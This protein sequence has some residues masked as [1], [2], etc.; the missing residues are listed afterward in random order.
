[1]KIVGTGP[2]ASPVQAVNPWDAIA[3]IGQG[4]LALAKAAGSNSL[5]GFA[6]V[7]SNGSLALPAST[8]TVSELINE[9]L[10]A[11]ARLDRS[12]RYL[13][14]LRVSLRSFGEGRMSR[15][16]ASVTVQDVE[17]WL[18][19]NGWAP[20]TMKGYLGDVRTMFN[21][22]IK[23]GYL[24]RS[25]ALAVELP[26]IDKRNPPE[27]YSPEEV[28]KILE[29]LRV[30]DLNVCR[31]VA[32][33]FFAGV[34]NAETHRLR[35]TDLKLDL[36]FVEVPALK[37]KTRARRLVKIRPNL[38]AW[39]E[40]GGEL[41]A[42]SDWT[43]RKALKKCGVPWKANAPRH[44]FVSYHLAQFNSAAKTAL[45][46]GHTEQMTFAHYRALVTPAAAE[47]FWSIYPKI[48]E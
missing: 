13:R 1:M 39:L 27:I 37:A 7:I 45:E 28:S 11:K 5:T 6:P 20:K 29:A 32:L 24:N 16:I 22:A 8:H 23:R 19:R 17:A 3:L 4:L 18:N 25:P 14:E 44:C 12:D 30:I 38:R 31:H 10:L 9:F 2:V 15:P 36:G 42:F 48:L 33:R 46:A 43:I 21:F 40:L 41:R 47:E 34:R 26:P 35:E